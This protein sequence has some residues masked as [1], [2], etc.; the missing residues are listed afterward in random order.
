MKVGKNRTQN[1]GSQAACPAPFDLTPYQKP[2]I[3]PQHIT[4]DMPRMFSRRFSCLRSCLVS[5]FA[6]ASG[7]TAAVLSNAVSMFVQA[8]NRPAYD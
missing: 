5:T 7:L 6:R 3:D 1:R 4:A 2:I 8:K